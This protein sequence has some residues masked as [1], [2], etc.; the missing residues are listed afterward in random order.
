[1]DSI[2]GKVAIITGSSRGIGRATA[3]RLARSGAKVVINSR[4]SMEELNYTLEEIRK[5]GA[6]C[7][8]VMADVSSRDGCR[9]IVDRALA[10]FGSLDI[11]VNNVGLGLYKPFMDIDDAMIDKQLNSTL[12]SAIICS[13]EAARRMASGCIINVASL[14]GALPIRGLSI[15]G[16]AKAGLI[17]ITRSLALE[18]APNIRVNGVAPTVVKT[19]MGESLLKV[20]GTNENDWAKRN[21][22][23]GS[24]IDPADVAEAIFFLITVTSM[25]G[26]TMVIDGGQ[27]VLGGFTA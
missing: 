27:S 10:E 21:S 19:R 7:I 12:K 14:A 2:D 9:L 26:Q 11:L 8:S 17:L 23:Y 13:Q 16:A 6:E 15:Y 1:M 18:L 20:T 4:H 5:T 24:L 3:I 22:L 25:N